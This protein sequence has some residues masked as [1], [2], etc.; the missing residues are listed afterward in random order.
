MFHYFET[1]DYKLVVFTLNMRFI[2]YQNFA[3]T[4]FILL[5]IIMLIFLGISMFEYSNSTPNFDKNTLDKNIFEDNRAT[6]KPRT[7]PISKL[8]IIPLTGFLGMLA[9]AIIFYFMAN[10]LDKN[11]N[12]QKKNT[13][14]ILN[15]LSKEEK[16]I[17][18]TLIKNR[19]ISFQYELN[20][21]AGLTRVK[22]HRILQNLEDKGIIKKEKYGKKNKIIL[23]DELY[24]VL[25]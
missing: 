1:N 24:E 17:I 6:P 21:A 10:K 25:K 18:E 7:Y 3:Y 15:F 9:G 8:F 22:T 19:G 20:R 5:A 11:I 12:V 13:K 14:I 2:T 4:F 16:G 23:N